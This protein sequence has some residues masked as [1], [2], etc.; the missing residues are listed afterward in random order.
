MIQLLPKLLTVMHRCHVRCASLSSKGPVRISDHNLCLVV[1]WPELIDPLGRGTNF[2]SIFFKLI[3]QQTS[4]DTRC[5]IAL[6]WLPEKL[7]KEKSTLVE[8]IAWCRQATSHYLSR[9]WRRSTYLIR[10]ATYPVQHMGDRLSRGRLPMRGQIL[11]C[12]GH[13]CKKKE[14][15]AFLCVVPLFICIGVGV[16]ST[17]VGLTL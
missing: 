5:E 4:L 13:M 3:M 1:P 16:R 8:V 10:A 17:R 7:T 11:F 14:N 2:K 12:H 6:S 15:F 9:C